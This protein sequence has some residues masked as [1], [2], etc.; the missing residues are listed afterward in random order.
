MRIVGHGI[1]L[2]ETA[3]IASMLERHGERFL[4]RVFTPEEQAHGRGSRRYAEHLAARFAA[5]EAAGKALGT[6]ISGGIGW[7][8]L[9]VVRGADGRPTMRVHGPAGARAA[10][11][12]V[13]EW[14]L[15][16]SHAGGFAAASVVL[17]GE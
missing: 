8:D 16:L 3:R 4:A 10:A 1:D 9:E 6:G 11:L 12:G 2:V 14:H 13:Q 5:K 15:S 7:T 17:C